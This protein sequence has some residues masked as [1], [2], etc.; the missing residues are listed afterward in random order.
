MQGLKGGS[1]VSG[2]T[3]SMFHDLLQTSDD[4][5]F[6]QQSGSLSNGSHNRNTL[7]TMQNDFLEDMPHN[8]LFVQAKHIYIQFTSCAGCPTGAKKD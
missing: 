5:H 6:L 1:S 8:S 4:H 7:N 2:I 3:Q